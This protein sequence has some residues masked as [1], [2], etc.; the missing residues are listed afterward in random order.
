MNSL[1]RASFA[2]SPSSLKAPQQA[3]MMLLAGPCRRIGAPTTCLDDCQVRL[4]G[5]PWTPILGEAIVSSSCFTMLLEANQPALALGLNYRVSSIGPI[6]GYE[7][8]ASRTLGPTR[9]PAR[10]LPSTMQ[11]C[12][13]ACI[14][15]PRPGPRRNGLW[16][17]AAG[18]LKRGLMRAVRLLEKVVSR[19]RPVRGTQRSMHCHCSWCSSTSLSPGLGLGN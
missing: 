16:V 12:R 7:I 5:R 1:T 2:S 15:N 17:R 9:L 4:S 3:G 11:A 14:R 18:M 10:S 19:I 8:S 6:Y 13:R